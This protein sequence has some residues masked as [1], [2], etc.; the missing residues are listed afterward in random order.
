MLR[1]TLDMDDV[2]A[3]T[4]EKLVSIVLN[5]FQSTLDK[6]DFEVKSL[7]ELLH[8][9]QLTRLHKVMN[10]PGF[11]ANIQVKKDAVET[12]YKLSRFYEIYVA[13]AAMEFPNSFKDK[14]DWLH[15]HFDFIPWSNIVFCGHKSIIHSDYLI[16]DHVRNLNAFKGE[17]ILF[18]AAHNLQ[19]KTY[20]RVSNWKDV[21]ELFLPN[22]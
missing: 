6:K 22:K 19:D 18:T 17:G 11:F 1:L 15:K 5:D 20:R 13:T 7:R 9:K 10:E 4:H 12:V 14:F 3:D 2:M 21:A 8:P 16:D